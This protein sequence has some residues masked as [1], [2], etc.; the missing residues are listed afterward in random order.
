MFGRPSMCQHLQYNH[1]FS[2]CCITFHISMRFNNLVETENLVNVKG[3]FPIGNRINKILQQVILNYFNKHKIQKLHIFGAFVVWT[4]SN[5]SSRP[6]K[7]NIK[8]MSL[9]FF[10]PIF[11]ALTNRSKA[12]IK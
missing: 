11:K 7:I 3:Y 6:L 4:R 2:F 10:M 1:K 5:F 9:I 12:L 8:I